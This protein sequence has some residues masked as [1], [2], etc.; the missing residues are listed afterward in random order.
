MRIWQSEAFFQ[1]AFL[2]VVALMVVTPAAAQNAPTPALAVAEVPQHAKFASLGIVLGLRGQTASSDG[3][4]VTLT[5]AVR[6]ELLEPVF[7]FDGFVVSNI[8]MESFAAIEG[9]SDAYRLLGL[10]VFEDAA[11]RRV[12]TEFAAYYTVT[13][14]GIVIDWASARTR[15][16]TA[17]TIVWFAVDPE[18]LTA[19]YRAPK[20]QYALMLLLEEQALL[21]AK[22]SGKRDVAIYAVSWDRFAADNMPIV[23]TAASDL[24]TSVFDLGGWSA[25]L[26]EGRIDTEQLGNGNMLELHFPDGRL[27]GQLDSFPVRPNLFN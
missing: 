7:R 25:V 16:P 21:K 13:Q 17:P 3:L 12:Y 19:A 4:P 26:F 23:A 14:S 10:I 5:S 20:S 22:G 15:T 11:A 8:Q 9:K 2:F 18:N 6:K 1:V 24:T 27:I